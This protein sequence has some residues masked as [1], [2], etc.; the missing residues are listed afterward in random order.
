MLQGLQKCPRDPFE[1]PGVFLSLSAG[2]KGEALGALVP[3]EEL[4]ELGITGSGHPGS[5]MPRSS[6][7]AKPSSPQL[8]S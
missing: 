3:G 7:S 5:K 1:I 8:F 4:G 6:D 2:G